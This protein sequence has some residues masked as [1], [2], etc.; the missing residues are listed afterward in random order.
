MKV[1]AFAARSGSTSALSPRS[2][3]VCGLLA[4]ASACRADGAVEAALHGDLATLRAAIARD[5]RAAGFDRERAL[6]LAR[7]VMEREITASRGSP[8]AGVVRRARSCAGPLADVLRERAGGEDETAAEATR[9]LIG[10]GRVDKEDLVT[11][12]ARASRA[13]WRTV[14]ARAAVAPESRGHRQLACEDPDERVRHAALEAAFEA[15]D[16]ADFDV[17]VDRSGRDPAPL[18]R[19]LA[20]RAL[21][22]I[23]GEASVLAL[24]D[25]F[26]SGDEQLRLAILDAWAMP[27]S[28]AAG[29]ERELLR[30]METLSGLPK[31]AAAVALLRV[32]KRH[33]P[34]ALSM[35][36]VAAREGSEE[37]RKLALRSLPAGEREAVAVWL[38]AAKA[39]DPDVRLVALVRLATVSKHRARAQREL[40]ELAARTDAHAVEAR[41]A[42][43]ELGDSR[44]LPELLTQLRS[45]SGRRR[46]LAALGLLRL[47]R[48]GLAAR[49]LADDD[50]NV[51]VT[52]ACSLVAEGDSERL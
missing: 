52:V 31:V 27:R 33:R 48:Y 9:V 7:A 12:H 46:Q 25:R 49:A 30:A 24:V 41:T 3:L 35:L 13:A 44:V 47:E 8:G 39:D 10:L 19:S 11:L 42:L 37:E 4:L 50:P 20:V 5:E 6:D 43:A 22:A 14:A 34:Q 36:E 29:G 32:S 23:G 51:R 21:G 40:A 18:N 26:S 38:E 2:L 45:P 15:R 16:V 17:L 28:L 1:A